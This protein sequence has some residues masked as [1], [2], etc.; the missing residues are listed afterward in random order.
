M[1]VRVVQEPPAA[2]AAYAT[3]S[4]AFEVDR[5]LDVTPPR[6]AGGEFALSERELSTPGMKDYDAIPGAGPG[7]WPERFDMS[8]WA[9]FAAFAEG[10]RV[11]GAA[12]ILRSE[13][14]ALL[15]G[16]DDIA[17][18]WD[19]RVAPEARGLGVGT[20]LL[21]AVEAWAVDQGARWLKVETQNVNVPACRFY[22]R[23]GF[24]LSEADADAYADFPQ[25]TQLIWLK[26]IDGN[27][28]IP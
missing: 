22:A 11:G 19:I 23:H 5:V 15:D 1:N 20:A 21:D 12:V 3:V 16:R 27:E 17:L 26:H 4:I 8:A 14:I 10:S 18:L 28:R 24:R 6:H 25:E 9:L 13:E 7:S 2:V